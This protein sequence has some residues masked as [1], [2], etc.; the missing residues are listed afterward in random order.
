MAWLD[1]RRDSSTLNDLLG[2]KRCRLECCMRRPIKKNRLSRARLRWMMP[3][4]TAHG[5]VCA[6]HRPRGR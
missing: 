4:V 5:S 2:T 6:S 1:V 3:P